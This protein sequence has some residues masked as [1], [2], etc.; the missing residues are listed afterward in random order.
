MDIETTREQKE[1]CHKYNA[2]Y[3]GCDQ[4]LKI[5][6]ADKLPSSNGRVINGL[7]HRPESGTS[8]WYIYFGAEAMSSE[9]DFFK[10]MH[11]KHLK[12]RYPNIEKYLGLPPGW[13]FL[14]ADDYEDVWYD[15]N[16]L[17]I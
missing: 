7:R 6:I 14:I 2:D 9:D 8:G 3:F 11:V 16:L 10:P 5:G 15:E 13:R 4:S 12:D 1:L 17:D